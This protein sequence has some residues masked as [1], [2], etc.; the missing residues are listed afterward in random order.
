MSLTD[1]FSLGC[2]LMSDAV[3]QTR[4]KV[5]DVVGSA[6]HYWGIDQLTPKLIVTGPPTVPGSKHT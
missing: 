6:C 4:V 5:D 2:V 1:D 3:E